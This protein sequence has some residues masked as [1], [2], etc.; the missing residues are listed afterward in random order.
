MSSSD[1]FALPAFIMSII[2]LLIAGVGAVTGAIALVWQIRTRT[3]GA[4]RVF[5]TS[6]QEFVA[7]GA[8][9]GVYLRVAVI[10][11]GAASVQLLSCGYELPDGIGLFA[12]T[13]DPGD[14]PRLPQQL[15]P[16]TQV[17]YRIAAIEIRERLLGHV[18]R[19]EGSIRPAV[20]LGTGELIREKTPITIGPDWYR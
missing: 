12:Y 4:H 1:V 17:S 9:G 20:E 14:G 11:A 10:N 3:R 8:S 16:G 19:T 6:G 13:F 5:V 15:E 18:G 7:S 2:G